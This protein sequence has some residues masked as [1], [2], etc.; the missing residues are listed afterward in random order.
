MKFLLILGQIELS[1]RSKC[2]GELRQLALTSELVSEVRPAFVDHV[3]SRLRRC[4]V[5]V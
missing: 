4:K 1:M 5:E 3:G 2:S